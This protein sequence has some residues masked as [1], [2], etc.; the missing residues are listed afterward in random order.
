MRFFTTAFLTVVLLSGTAQAAAPKGVLLDFT[1]TWCGPC[2]KMSPLI[3]RLKR[4]GY[5]IKKVDVDQE[6]DLAKRFNV[7]SIP[8]FVLVV[9]G[10]EVARSVG[11]TTESNLRRMLAR[12]PSTEPEQP[13]RENPVMFAANENRL[14]QSEEPPVQLTQ[15]ETKPEKKS[16]GFNIPF[17]GKSKEEESVPVEEPVIRAQF[18]DSASD[19]LADAAP[20]KEI[21]NWRASTVR[22]RVK[23]KKG[24][25]LGSGT[26][27]HSA[28]GRTLI[29]TCSH[30]FSELKSD[31]LIEVDVFQ[32]EKFDTYVGTLVRYN[33]QADVGLISI[34]TSGV[35]S[36]A[37]VAGIENEV[38]AGDVVASIGCNGGA[39]PTLEKIQVTELNRFLGP[40]N[41]E[42]TGMPVQGRSGGGL[43]DRSGRL[44]G[45][46][47][48]VEKDEKRGL[49][50]GLPMIHKLLDEAQ[51]TAIYKEPAVTETVPEDKLAM[52]EAPREM[53]PA[54]NQEILDEF[55]ERAMPTG[56]PVASGT[57][58]NPD[59]NQ[60]QAALDQAGEAEVVCII[61]P[62]NK[63]QSA[64]RVVI[65]NKASSK[66]V[67]YLSGEVE[68]QPVPTSARFQPAESLSH[69]EQQSR[70]L[71]EERMSRSLP[72]NTRVNRT[73]SAAQPEVTGFRSP[74]SFTQ[75]SNKTTV[76]REERQGKI[77]EV[78][79]QLRRYRRSADSRR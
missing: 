49:Y 54:H 35:V 45:V 34:P 52:S 72:R 11:S 61:R 31:S 33:M 10:K 62:L 1:A 29:M 60:L 22:I 44:V 39:F 48:A 66:F 56:Q 37:Q 30:I 43:F 5:P 75:T 26:V 18:G 9:E 19:P 38:K 2:Q 21:I 16:R 4:E 68:N 58:G 64:S 57:T 15:N 20:Q 67:S 13:A 63:P 70:D 41:I 74:A 32:G 53:A 27:I 77:Q 23:D 6:P 59:L 28:V 78:E 12:I 65:I 8:A 7:T 79:Q 46:C 14:S 25:D 51:L 40:D 69:A 3:S 55:L 50:V 17:F 76:S 42:C 73:E 47:F 36:A 24:M 71:Q